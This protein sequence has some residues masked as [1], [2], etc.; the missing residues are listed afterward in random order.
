V[1]G[2]AE[3]VM[4]HDIHDW[5]VLG[6]SKRKLGSGTDGSSENYDDYSTV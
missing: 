1:E 4:S 6:E 5:A 3:F 2:S